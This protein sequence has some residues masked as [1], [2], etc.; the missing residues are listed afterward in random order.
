MIFKI[1]YDNDTKFINADII[2]EISD[3]IE[4]NDKILFYFIKNNK[5]LEICLYLTASNIN[6]KFTKFKFTESYNKMIN[7]WAKNSMKN[8]PYSTFEDHIIELPF[9]RYFVDDKKDNETTTGEL[10]HKIDLVK[11]ELD[12]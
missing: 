3:I 4:H 7:Q 10:K 11:K 5:E 12:K 6:A 8:R 1:K 2:N 9:I